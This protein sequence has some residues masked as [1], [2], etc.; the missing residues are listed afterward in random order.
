M[1]WSLL[2][3]LVLCHWQIVSAQLCNG[4]LGENIFEEGDFGAGPTNLLSPDPGIAPG[5]TYTFDVPPVDGSYTVTNNTAP[6]SNLWP[7]WLR[8]GDNSPDPNGYMMVVNASFS[9]GIFFRQTVDGLCENTTYEFSADIIN[10]I[11]Q[12]EP[13]HIRPNVSFELDGVTRLNTGEVP[14]STQWI[15]YGFTFQT[16]PGVEEVTLTI[17]NNAPGGIGNDLALD[18]ISFRT[19]GNNAFINTPQSIFICE[20]DNDPAPITAEV[21]LNQTFIQWQQSLDNGNTWNN[22]IGEEDQIYFHNQ[23]SP[24]IYWYRYLSASSPD[25]LLNFKC[26]TLSDQVRI[27]VLPLIYAQADTICAGATFIFGT[28]TLTDSGQYTANLISSIGCDSIVQLDLTVVENGLVID[29]DKSLPSCPE[30]ANGQ[31]SILGVSG[32]APPFRYLL[33]TMEQVDAVFTDLP[34][35]RYLLRVE[36]RFQCSTSVE[37]DLINDQQF[38][39]DAGEDL[40]LQFGQSPEFVRVQS[41]QVIQSISWTPG[42]F[43]SCSSCDEVQVSAAQSQTYVIEALN[44]QGCLA[45]DSLKLTVLAEELRIYIP[46]AFSPNGDGTNDFFTVF[47]F[48]QTVSAISSMRVF[49]RWGALVYEAR[50]I[51]PNVIGLGWDG[52]R[53]GEL[54]QSGVYTYLIEL[55]LL[56]GQILQRSGSITILR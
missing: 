42:A 17:R 52:R 31:I 56:D 21:D 24:G 39:I 47:S 10:L 55:E 23:F 40:V 15:T 19:C 2:I 8:I 16:A 51:P 13:G 38:S 36:D 29:V 44:E 32:G 14:Q 26:R 25:N 27:E 3:L 53:N 7:S 18:N 1:K 4:N 35:D 50:E 41:N 46:N 12:V 20:D 37:V 48:E 30:D 49:N 54:M 22:L 6:W 11:R 5:Y 28:D 43:L 33:D 34:S 45:T 9:P